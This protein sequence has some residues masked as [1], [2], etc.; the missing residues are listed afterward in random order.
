MYYPVL[1]RFLC[2]FTQVV[3]DNVPERGILYYPVWQASSPRKKATNS[4]TTSSKVPASTASP[5]SFIKPTS[6]PPRNSPRWF[7]IAPPPSP[8]PPPRSGPSPAHYLLLAA[9]HR[10]CQPGPKT[11][12]PDWYRSSI[13]ST[14][15]EFPA[16]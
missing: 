6:V 8:W 14:L 5:V 9:I 2:I 4:T 1:S 15:W 12:V 10:I 11:E 16:E 7:A 13:L 3:L